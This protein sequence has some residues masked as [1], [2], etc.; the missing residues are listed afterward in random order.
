[1]KVNKKHIKFLSVLLT[2]CVATAFTATTAFADGTTTGGTNVQRTV[3]KS[4][5]TSTTQVIGV[6][7]IGDNS[8]T[9]YDSGK[10]K[11]DYSN[12]CSEHIQS[13]I[14]NA[15]NVV[16]KLGAQA[17]EDTTAHAYYEGSTISSS[18]KSY[19]NRQ[20]QWVSDDSEGTAVLVGDTDYYGG[21]YDTQGNG[22]RHMLITGKYGKETVYIIEGIGTST[23][24]DLEKIDAVDAT[25]TT[26]GNNEYY[27]CTECGKYFKDIT[28]ING[29][30]P[31][32]EVIPKLGHSYVWETVIPATAD[33]EGLE[34]EV[35]TLCG[36][37]TGKTQVIEKLSDGTV[38]EDETPSATESVTE[39]VTKTESTPSEAT[40]SEATSAK[41]SSSDSTS[42]K[43][44]DSTTTALWLTLLITSGGVLI[45]FVIKSRKRKF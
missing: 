15:K 24:H 19:D 21:T 17:A 25:C 8:T 30:T 4:E 33:S 38:A 29:T 12:P 40:A 45:A 14:S 32:D 22:D 41:Q 37:H 16:D 20:Y 28:A 27:R 36:E 3:D 7:T 43:T 1:M 13:L 26:D 34:E 31:E 23:P 44:G 18:S 9:V 11:V 2:M 42:P 39:N 35:C 10:V 6:L 5:D